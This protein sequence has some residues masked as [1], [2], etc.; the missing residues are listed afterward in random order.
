M[1]GE[2]W[3]EVYN[4]EHDYWERKSQKYTNH[5]KNKENIIDIV[6]LKSGVNEFKNNNS[7]CEVEEWKEYSDGRII[8]KK[9]SD[10]GN[11][12]RVKSETGQKLHKERLKKLQRAN[13]MNMQGVPEELLL[14]D[15]G[16]RMKCL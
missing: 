3:C 7:F 11:G 2:K 16:H 12:R 1:T 4:S 10:N 6:L 13:V 5:Q 15:E 14:D 9:L 8:K